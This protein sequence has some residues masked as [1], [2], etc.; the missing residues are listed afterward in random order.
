MIRLVSYLSLVFGCPFTNSLFT[1]VC[2]LFGSEAVKTR[3]M[4]L[5]DRQK[6]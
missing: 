6:V 5:S 1:D 2:H 4:P 3:M